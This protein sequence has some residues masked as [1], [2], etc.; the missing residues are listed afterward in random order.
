MPRKRKAAEAG[1]RSGK[2]QQRG[3]LPS[4]ASILQS[5]TE[6]AAAAASGLSPELAAAY[7]AYLAAQAADVRATMEERLRSLLDQ[8][9][10]GA[11]VNLMQAAVRRAGSGGD[12]PTV[13]DAPAPG[14]TAGPAT[15]SGAP[16]QSQPQQQAREQ[17]K[18]QGQR[19]RAQ[20]ARHLKQAQQPKPDPDAEPALAQLLREAAHD[21]AAA[22][23]GMAPELVAAFLR[24]LPG[25]GPREQ[26]DKEG[27]LMHMV[28]RRRF[29]AAAA[30]MRAAV[31]Q[32]AGAA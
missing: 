31:E 7:T 27:A 22:A 10:F 18:K 14:G 4:L 3:S 29:A 1:S 9:R 11:A 28:Q 12:E 20:Q 24:L 2:R 23:E 17:P 26:A 13:A 8:Q 21:E 25:L 30:V 15:R 16:S 19:A 6:Q 32:H 5:A